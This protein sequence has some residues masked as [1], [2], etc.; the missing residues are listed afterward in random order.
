MPAN[1][2][3]IPALADFR[4][5]LLTFGEVAKRAMDEIRMELQRSLGW[6]GDEQPT[7]WKAEQQRAMDLVAEKRNELDQCERRAYD[8]QRPTCYAERKALEASKRYV[9]YVE[10]KAEVV[11]RWG[12]TLLR[13]VSEYD[14]QVG[15]FRDLLDADLPKAVILLDRMIA[16]LEAYTSVTAS[17]PTVTLGQEPVS[18]ARTAVE[19]EPTPAIS[20][21]QHLREFTPSLDERR[22]HDVAPDDELPVDVWLGDASSQASPPGQGEPAS[23]PPAADEVTCQQAALKTAYEL[24]LEPALP[25]WNAKVLLVAGCWQTAQVYLERVAAE[26]ED[27]SGWFIGPVQ[28][29]LGAVPQYQAL[30]LA[31]LIALR[32]GLLAAC[33]LPQGYLAVFSGD[34]LVAVVNEDGHDLWEQRMRK[35]LEDETDEA[36]EGRS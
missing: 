21:F 16:A 10:E 6:V 19:T 5:A 12:R 4:A 20:I 33:A 28:P 25:D 3:S 35:L 9:R 22:E 36:K 29:L 14:A 30:P 24:G 27:D 2:R 18:I 11:R 17:P 26:E 34:E 13:D 32:P 15:K 31:A 7:F 23:A 8:G 1:V